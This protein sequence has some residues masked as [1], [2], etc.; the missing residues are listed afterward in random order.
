MVANATAH[1]GAEVV[2]LEERSLPSLKAR[3]VIERLPTTGRLLEIG[4][5]DGKILRTVRAHKPDLELHGCDVRE[6][7][8]AADVYAFRR[9]ERDLPFEDQSLDV[10]LVVDV[11]EHVPDPRHL[12]A[13]AAR[14]LRPGG[15][16]LAFVPVEGEALS[17]YELFR[18]LL[19]RDTYELTKEHIQ[20]FT[21]VE[22]R[23][24]IAQRFDVLETRYAYHLLGQLMDAA[25]FAA[26][27]LKGLRDM[28]W[29]SNVFYNPD[30]K[31]MGGKVGAMNRFLV[32]G[33][34]LAATE[35]ELLSRTRLGSAGVLVE[36]VVRAPSRAPTT[37]APL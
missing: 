11:L 20:S 7:S 19:G 14:V 34:V 26:A 18:R 13:E 6:P 15:R 10:V 32:A 29:S 2:E 27:R 4:C 9:M 31:G 3:F 8:H 23:A 22:A 33:N 37:A 25:F 30:A 35:S 16:L 12:L 24:L 5:G 1:W 21:H 36:A 28:W 17:F